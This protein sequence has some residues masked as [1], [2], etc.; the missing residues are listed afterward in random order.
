MK[1]LDTTSQLF[2][3]E[4]AERIAVEMNA[5]DNWTYRPVHDPKSTGYSFIEVYDEDG[6]AAI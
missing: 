1:K 6:D 3:K 2:T 5:D 4:E